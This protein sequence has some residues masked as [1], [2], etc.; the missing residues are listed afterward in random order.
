MQ[1]LFYVNKV[2]FIPPCGFFPKCSYAFIVTS[3]PLGV[4]CR[5]PSCIRKGSYTS[6]SVPDSSPTAVAMVVIPTG[7][8]LNLSMMVV[9]ILL[10][11]SSKPNSSTFNALR[12]CCVQPK[13]IT[14]LP[15]TMAKSRMRRNNP[16][17]IRGVARLRPAISLAA[18]L[19]I[20]TFNIPDA[21]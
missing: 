11:I 15:N 19:V 12:P 20:F 13:S 9:R 3:L 6:S 16:F 7:P 5:N 10:S 14:P 2:G 17:A 18:S 1:R 21:R 4:R 8:P